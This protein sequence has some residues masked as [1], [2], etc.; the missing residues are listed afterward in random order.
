MTNHAAIMDDLRTK[1]NMLK[2]TKVCTQHCVDRESLAEFQNILNGSIV[3]CDSYHMVQMLYMNNRRSFTNSIRGTSN[4]AL[5]MW[6]D[7]IAI[8]DVLKLHNL[9]YILFNKETSK[10]EV[11]KYKGVTKKP[12]VMTKDLISDYGDTKK[13]IVSEL[14]TNYQQEEAK[15]PWADRD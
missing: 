10:Y 3:I 6:C 7:F 9:V 5:V 14:V 8:I 15:K 4:E 1:Y 12:A 11:L 2:H 13:E